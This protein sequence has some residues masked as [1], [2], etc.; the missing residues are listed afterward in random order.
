[1]DHPVLF[2]TFVREG[3]FKIG[4]VVSLFFDLEKA[5]NTNWKYGIMEDLYDMVRS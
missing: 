4:N 3:S 5:Y 2:K 1:M